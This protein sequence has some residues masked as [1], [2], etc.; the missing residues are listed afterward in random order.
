MGWTYVASGAA[1][2][3]NNATSLT[4]GLP[5]GWAAGD[6]HVAEFQN[7]G[8]TGNRV[9]S[10]AAGWTPGPA[11]QNGTA[12]HAV[13]WRQAQLGDAAPTITLTGT[14]VAGD[15]QLSR[16]HGF[17]PSGSLVALRIT[18]AT[19]TNSTADNVGPV[20]GISPTFGDLVVASVGKTNDFNG[21]ASAT[22][23]SL[24]AMSES[25][26]GND[27][28]M[29]CLYAVSTGA[30]TGNVTV[31]DTG[32][33][34]SNGLGF[35]VLLAF[36]TNVSDSGAATGVAATEGAG[37]VDVVVVPIR[38]PGSLRT[39]LGLTGT[40]WRSYEIEGLSGALGTGQAGTLTVTFGTSLVV[41]SGSA[42]G[43]LGAFEFSIDGALEPPGAWS[44]AAAG[45]VS[46]GQTFN[47]IVDLSGNAGAGSVGLFAITHAGSA[48]LTGDAATGTAGE[49]FV[50]QAFTVEAA[51]AFGYVGALNV[52]GFVSVDL[53]SVAMTGTAN[54]F[55]FPDQ[56]MQSRVTI[57]ARVGV[58]AY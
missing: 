13:F 18:G 26:T 1:S 32:A 22:G 15:T 28:G 10:M 44:T 25:T 45:S 48:S 54:E 14:G 36:Y 16:I 24:A 47:E 3:G 50:G 56:M 31:T 37:A 35:G 41:P 55:T 6:L 38:P 40:P 8:G 43:A 9:P 19:S 52:A 58:R 51:Q 46:V 11:W 33:T 29:A 12:R 2:N 23:F 7:F 4:P 49:V 39:V 27:A 21:T 20:T 57:T 42:T 17:R 30:S 53:A 34:A 5:A